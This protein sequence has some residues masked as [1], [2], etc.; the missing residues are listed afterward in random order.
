MTLTAV[1]AGGAESTRQGQISH[2]GVAKWTDAIVETLKIVILLSNEWCRIREK[3]R[4]LEEDEV[5]EAN[6]FIF[7]VL[8][9]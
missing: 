8:C 5:Q 3:K 6:Q 4:K 7:N 9:C 2:Y 1:G